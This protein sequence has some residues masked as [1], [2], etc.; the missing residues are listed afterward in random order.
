MG[1]KPRACAPPRTPALPGT[2]WTK[3]MLSEYK[4][5]AGAKTNVVFSPS[6]SFYF[7]SVLHEPD[8][9]PSERFKMVC[10]HASR[11]GRRY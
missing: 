5:A 7:G 1:G 10:Q 11:R 3:P 9:P 4:T 8:R 2:T 6:P